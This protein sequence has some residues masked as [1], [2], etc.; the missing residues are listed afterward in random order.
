MITDT[1]AYTP[2]EFHEHIRELLICHVR[3]RRIGHVDTWK[4]SFHTRPS[5]IYD[6]IFH[7]SNDSGYERLRI[8]KNNRM[9]WTSTIYAGRV[10]HYG[11]MPNL[12]DN[13]VDSNSPADSDIIEEP[14]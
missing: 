13:F 9:S 6:V 5:N 4:T 3:P 7:R 2:K 10:V 12:H 8:L 11:E 1:E 14:F